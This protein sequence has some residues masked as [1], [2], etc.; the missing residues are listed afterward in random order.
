MEYW[1]GGGIAFAIPCWIW[2][3]IIIIFQYQA[4]HCGKEIFFL[5]KTHGFSILGLFPLWQKISI[6]WLLLQGLPR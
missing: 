4:F 5:F 2:L 1:Y 3:W 6:R